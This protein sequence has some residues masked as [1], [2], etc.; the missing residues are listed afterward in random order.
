MQLDKGKILSEARQNDVDWHF[1]PP[2]ASNFGGFY[3]RM[4]RSVRSVLAAQLGV[5][6]PKMTTEVLRTV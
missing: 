3:E 4:I 2:L 6:T 5:V 1:N